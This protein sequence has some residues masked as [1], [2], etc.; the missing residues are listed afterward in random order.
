MVEETNFTIEQ[1]TP[2]AITATFP[3]RVTIPDHPFVAG[4]ALRATKFY[5]Y[6][7][8]DSTG[9]Y[10]L[11]NRLFYVN[12]VD[13]DTFGLYDVYGNGIDGTS[14]TPFISNGKAQFTLTGPDLFVQN[15]APL[16][17]PGIPVPMGYSNA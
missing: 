11:N 6:P 2:T 15:P 16:P 5:K 9:M 8:A 14:F 4:N 13:G 3:V 10:Q 17:P 1:Y 7:L 12:L